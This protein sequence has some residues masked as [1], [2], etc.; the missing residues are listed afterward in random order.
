M[1]ARRLAEIQPGWK[2]FASDGGEVG[3]VVAASDATLR[4]KKGRLLGRE[5][6]LPADVIAQVE[7]GRVDLS[8][9]KDV[10]DRG[11]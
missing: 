7:T 11:W 4:V 9:T 3:T 5:V 8:V 6:T 2:V 10:L 1:T